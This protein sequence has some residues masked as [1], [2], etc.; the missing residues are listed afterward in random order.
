MRQ[1][2]LSYWLLYKGRIAGAENKL[3]LIGLG[4]WIY[5]LKPSEELIRVLCIMKRL[6]VRVI[7]SRLV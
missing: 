3:I 1:I 6:D 5:V 7:R 4:G 2:L